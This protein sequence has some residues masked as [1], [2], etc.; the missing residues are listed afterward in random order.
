MAL[1]EGAAQK[2]VC[3]SSPCPV[4]RLT[5]SPP[6]CIADTPPYTLPPSYL[7]G[8]EPFRVR[9]KQFY[10]LHMARKLI[11]DLIP[12]LSHEADGLILQVW[13]G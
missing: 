11:Q 3:A 7:Y 9:R 13:M 4:S 10:L 1:L 2:T 6:T 5:V 8:D 12:S